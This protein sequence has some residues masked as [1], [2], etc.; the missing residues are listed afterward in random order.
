MNT[1][2]IGVRA[3]SATTAPNV[4]VGVAAHA[5]S[6]ARREVSELLSTDDADTRA[7]DVEYG[8]ISWIGAI[9]R[10]CIDDSH[11]SHTYALGGSVAP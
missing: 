2:A 11:H 3:T 7:I 9:D 8:Y 4:T 1:H 10:T 5:L 6:E